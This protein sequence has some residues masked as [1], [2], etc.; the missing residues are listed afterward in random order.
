MEGGIKKVDEGI[1]AQE[2]GIKQHLC[3][4]LGDDPSSNGVAGTRRRGRRVIG[5][6]K[7]A[8]TLGDRG[9]YLFRIE[10]SP[11]ERVSLIFYPDEFCREKRFVAAVGI[12]IIVLHVGI[13]GT[14]TRRGIVLC[15]RLDVG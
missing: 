13:T 11:K 7:R 3:V 4:R 2:N 15:V 14:S 8:A 10:D 12:F 1:E 9:W 5:G 6:R